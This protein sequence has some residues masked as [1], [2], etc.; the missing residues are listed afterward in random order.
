MNEKKER[1][2]TGENFKDLHG[3]TNIQYRHLKNLNKF[4]QKF[5]EA[6]PEIKLN[7]NLSN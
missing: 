5:A 1:L 2:T 6:Y 7:F 4:A 3:V